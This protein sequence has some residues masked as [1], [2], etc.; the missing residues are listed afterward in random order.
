KMIAAFD[1][2]SGRAVVRAVAGGQRGN[3]VILPRETFGA[4]RQLVGD[5]GA[6]HIVERCGLPVIDVEL[7][8]AARLDL[9]TPEAILAAGG[10]LKE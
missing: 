7:G 10:V 1:A 2:E 4:V 5:V 9:D 3:P 8:A 6:R